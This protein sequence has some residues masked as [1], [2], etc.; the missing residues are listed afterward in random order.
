MQD[1]CVG[2][3]IGIPTEWKSDSLSYLWKRNQITTLSSESFSVTNKNC[4]KL[5]FELLGLDNEAYQIVNDVET[6]IQLIG[7]QSETDQI[8]T[9]QF[10]IRACQGAEK[11]CIESPPLTIE[12]VDSCKYNEILPFFVQDIE[13]VHYKTI[14]KVIQGLPF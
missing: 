8:G 7:S 10:T 4:G 11:S 3:E 1:E 5:S 14:N 12:V 9:K 6:G 2:A 13:V